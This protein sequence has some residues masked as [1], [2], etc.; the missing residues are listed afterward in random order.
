MRRIKGDSDALETQRESVRKRVEE[1]NSAP[2]ALRELRRQPR[3]VFR[4]LAVC[5]EQWRARHFCHLWDVLQ[6]C[7]GMKGGLEQ[8]DDPGTVS[9]DKQET[10]S[11]ISL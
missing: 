8:H 10:Y 4:W 1:E 2:Q 9:G 5:L 6:I 11:F 3:G 7:S